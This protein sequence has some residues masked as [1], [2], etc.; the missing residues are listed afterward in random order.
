R[1]ADR[2]SQL[3]LG[4][5]SVPFLRTRAL[6][7]VAF[8][9]APPGLVLDCLLF[10]M[11]E[12]FADRRGHVSRLRQSNDR[13]IARA[14]GDLSFVAAL[15]DREHNLGFKLIAQNLADFAECRFNVLA[16]GGSDFVVSA[17]VFH[18]HE[19]RSLV[20]ICALPGHCFGTDK[21]ELLF[22]PAGAVTLSQFFPTAC[23]VGCILTP[24]RGC[25]WRLVDMS[26]TSLLCAGGCSGSAD[27]P[28]TSPP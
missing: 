22:C 12:S 14:D 11:V 2:D 19:C 9:G 1:K 17:G 25:G 13:S 6:V 21:N 10:Q 16:D 3:F 4:R 7:I 28:G 18:V 15:L 20:S 27:P 26:F 23:A 24:L 8:L 5:L